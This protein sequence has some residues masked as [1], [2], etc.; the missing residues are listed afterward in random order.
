MGQPP[1]ENLRLSRCSP[2]L[3]AFFY[4]NMVE[5]LDDLSVSKIK[6]THMLTYIKED[7]RSMLVIG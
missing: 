2:L 1:P 3:F 7:Q 5:A 4:K 6:Q